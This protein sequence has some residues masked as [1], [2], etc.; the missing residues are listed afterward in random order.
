MQIDIRGLHYTY[1]SG[2]AALRA[3]SLHIAAGERVAIVGQNGS[4]KTTLAR[5]LNGLLRPAQGV[6]RI[7]DWSTA[8]RSTAQLALR[9]GYV[10]Q[11]PDEQLCK[12]RVRDEIAFGAVN[13]GFDAG[14]VARQ[15]AWAAGRWQLEPHLAANP[16]DLSPSWRR[17]VAIASVLA[18]DTPIVVLDEPTTGQDSRFLAQLAG[19]LDELQA[20]GKTV[21]A[22]SHDMD[23]VAEQFQRIVVMG[24]GRVLLDGSPHAV[25]GQADV[26]ATTHL[27]PPQL[28]RLGQSLELGD[29]V[30]TT[31]EFLHT[32]STELRAGT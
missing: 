12:R 20:L 29:T 32:V 4:G 16:H 17:R 27:L 31:D 1:P 7:G 13:L 25:F 22:I 21:V 5:H 18:M 2:V 24:E 23:F 14:R 3:V 8:D 15:V 9:V 19:L 6:V 26:L 11:N 28:T 10:F 30:C